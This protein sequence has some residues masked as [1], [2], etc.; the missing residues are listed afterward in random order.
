[1]VRLD[2]REFEWSLDLQSSCEARK[3]VMAAVAVWNFPVCVTVKAAA[4]AAW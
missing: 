4:L 2:F 3:C 1:M